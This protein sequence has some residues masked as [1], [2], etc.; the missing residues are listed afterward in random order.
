MTTH[1]AE[2]V[3]LHHHL[4]RMM[5][6]DPHEAHRA[7]TPLELLFD[8]AFVV[9]FAQAGAQMAHLVAEGHVVAAVGAFAFAMFA[10]CWAWMN[11]TWFASA[12]DTDDWFFRAATMVQMIGVLVLALGMPNLFHS[13]DEGHA[14]DN[15]T[16]VAGYIIMRVAMVALWLRAASHDPTR[17]NVAL[18]YAGIIIISQIGWVLAALL[19]LELI[20]TIAISLVL[21]SFELI[22]PFLA[23]R[24]GNTPWHAHHIAER[25]GLLTI[26]ALGEGVFGTVTTVSAVVEGHGW[27]R[28]A[29][30]LVVAGIGL[31]FGLWWNYFL[32]PSANVL[33]RHR[34]RAIAW[35][36]GHI[37]LFASVAATGAGL[38]VAAYVVEGEATISAG[39]AVLAVTIPVFVFL[40][41]LYAIYSNL[42]REFDP[43]HLALF[44]ASVAIEVIA[45]VL[46]FTGAPLSLCLLLVTLSPFVTV[47]GYETIGHRHAA[48]ALARV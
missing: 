11:F 29:I 14:I 8:L 2:P 5:G 30:T 16:L 6:R 13:I 1:P 3:G 31:T 38:H 17:R 9:A 41:A 33:A 37:P 7:A 40:C 15:R 24:G 36:Y 23:E 48:A 46:A 27:S 12:F 42:L 45:V 35:A 47:V 19:P 39:G 43:F 34:S 26:I 20:P 21:F 22:T 4:R 28:E 18:R 32:I 10:I 25:Y 44:A